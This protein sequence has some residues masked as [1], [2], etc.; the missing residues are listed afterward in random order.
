MP[1]TEAKRMTNLAK[2]EIAINDKILKAVHN[3]FLS[4]EFRDHE[5]NKESID[6]LTKLGYKVKENMAG[7]GAY[8]DT[9]LD[10]YTVYW[11]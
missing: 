11:S 6:K 4:V 2:A 3:G 7:G 8:E 10:S 5:L 1:A 9:Y